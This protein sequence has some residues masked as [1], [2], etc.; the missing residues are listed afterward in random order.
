MALRWKRAAWVYLL[1]IVALA[2]RSAV[3]DEPPGILMIEITGLKQATGNVYIAVYDSESTWLGDEVV[4]HKKVVIADAM[5]GELVRT[6][7]QLPMDEYAV[8]VFHDKDGNGELNTNLIGIPKEPIAVTNNA[9]GKFGPPK[10][11]DAKFTLGAE[12]AI[13]RIILREME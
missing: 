7:L 5:D 4:M 2:C 3:A 10:Y 1:L 11:E 12:P 9:V 8:S 6:E 13:Q